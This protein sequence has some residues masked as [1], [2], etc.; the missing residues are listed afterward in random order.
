M[1]NYSDKNV[2]KQNIILFIGILL[3]F[4]CFAIQANAQLIAKH[5]SSN[6]TNLA[7]TIIQGITSQIQLLISVVL[8]FKC[9]KKGF[10]SSL[11]L[12]I[13][14]LMMI[15]MTVFVSGSYFSA[16]GYSTSIMT[17]FVITIISL[18]VKKLS[19]NAYSMRQLAFADDL[20]GLPNRKR[21]LSSLSNRT[22]NE[23]VHT[24]FSLVL[25]DL[26][27]FKNI[28]DSL[29][30]QI[31]DL[32]LKEVAHNLQSCLLEDEF[33][34]RTGGD[35]FAVIIPGKH[36]EEEIYHYAQKI[37]ASISSPF[38]YRNNNITVTATFGIVQ[39][40]KD[41]ANSNELLQRA[42]MAMYRGKALGKGRISFF[43]E[44]M[45]KAL[46]K[47][48]NIET[49]LHTAIENNEMYLEYQPQFEPHNH[50]LRGF[51][52]LARWTS[53]TLGHVSPG[54]FIPIA[55][56]TGD[57]VPM[58]KWIMETACTQYMSVYDSYEIPPILAI[59]ISAVQ[60][61]DPDF[62][63]SIKRII[64]KT[65]MDTDHLE[66]EITES[67]CI[68]SPEIIAAILSQLK[69]VGIEIAMDDFGT[70]YSSL[71][72]LKNLPFDIV[73]IDITFTKTILTTP[74]EKNLIKPI[75]AMAHQLGLK[76]IAEGVEE[77]A[78]LEYLVA[79]GCDYIQGNIYGRPAP[80]GA[81]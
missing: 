49:N 45:Q 72:Y 39:F 53:P 73:K 5:F 59:N 20:T 67:V 58:G 32:L 9:Y 46:E 61:K 75:I 76:V 40:P 7:S 77:N 11:S 74:P 78:E 43:N 36:S 60:L 34:G 65:K 29:G 63:D 4:C 44:E 31:G 41:G 12:N 62:V 51:E 55:E 80:I 42:D 28:N 22:A 18:Q 50:K 6:N 3:F 56:E 26:D 54:E 14:N 81:L 30:H 38:V 57:I 8:T 70:G 66:L 52:A 17:I 24:Y 25:I 69:N 23:N 35:E 19:E 1:Q 15:S 79:N 71:S 47:R 64:N 16:V 33:L 2:I 13:I 27:E 48:L 37:A 10:F 68:M 21:F